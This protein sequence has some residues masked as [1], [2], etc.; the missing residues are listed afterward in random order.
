MKGVIAIS[1]LLLLAVAASG[2]S[3]QTVGWGAWPA[4]YRIEAFV[5]HAPAGTQV[6]ETLTV[7][8]ATRFRVLQIVAYQRLTDGDPWGLV[9]D[10]GALHPDFLLR[11]RRS[12]VGAILEAPPGAHLQGVFRH[13]RSMHTLL[14]DPSQLTIE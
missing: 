6:L 11:G 9:A 12:A 5:D 4:L 7:G 3:A 14:P 2:A 10:L 13:Y 8:T 1:S